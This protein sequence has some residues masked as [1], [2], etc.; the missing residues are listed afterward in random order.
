MDKITGAGFLVFLD[1]SSGQIED[2]EK[3]HLVLCL[4]TNDDY[5]DFPKGSIDPGEFSLDCAFREMRE[6]ANLS[7]DDIVWS[8]NL[9]QNFVCGKL[10]VLYP[11]IVK[12]TSIYNIK[13]KRN[14]ESGIIEHKGHGWHS[15]ESCKSKVYPF[16]KDSLEWGKNILFK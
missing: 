15:I 16:L 12:P 2:L 7:E 10:L 9:D 1:N 13:C 5:Y 8:G 4:Y 6:E 11:A 14:P 3:D